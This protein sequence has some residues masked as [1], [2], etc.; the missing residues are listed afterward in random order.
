MNIGIPGIPCGNLASVVR[1]I[2]RCGGNAGIAAAPAD[3]ARFDG[4]ILAGVGAF[5]YGMT[6]LRDAG[7]VEALNEAVIA[8][9][10]PVL[11]ICLGMQLMCSSSEEGSSPGLRW[12]DAEVR[13]FRPPAGSNLKVPH[14]GW[15]TIDVTHRNFLLD[16]A[17]EQRFYFV[18]SYYV[19]C[20][21]REQVLA[22]AHH[23]TDF[24]AA[25][26]NGSNIFGVQFHPEKSHRFGMALLQ[27][28]LGLKC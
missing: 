28:F 3:L 4:V 10:K 13:R 15:N 11:G 16:S 24:D 14:M 23:G 12:M 7:W 25:F 22:T 9:R 27:R 6:C 8:R 21:T 19:A 20:N 5:D 17:T 26:H 2:E 1:M 18:H